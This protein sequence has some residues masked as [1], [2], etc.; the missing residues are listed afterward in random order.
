MPTGTFA[1]ST[2]KVMQFLDITDQVQKAV[3]AS[4]VQ[5]GICH[6]Y[7]PH[8]TAGLT[9]NEGADPTVQSDIIAALQKIV[10]QIAYQHQEGNS[11]AHVMASLVGSSVTV[12]IE[13]GRLQL[14]TWQK[15]FFCEFD[16]P[17]SRKVFWRLA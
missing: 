10:P 2:S 1:L 13:N 7:N 15:I 17:R 11:P 16:G 12:F 3:S 8:T 6:V 5:D 9:I 4:G 14:G